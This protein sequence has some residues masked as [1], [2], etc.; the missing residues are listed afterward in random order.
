MSLRPLTM[1]LVRDLN[2]ARGR[3]LMMALALSLGVFSVGTVMSAYTI[4]TREISR[5]YLGTHPASAM[6]DIDHMEDSLLA[7]VRQ[8]PGIVDAEAGA[9]LLTRAQVKP[10]EWMPLLLFVVRDFNTSRI[11]TFLPESG[12][13]PP[14]DGTML[15]ERAALPL[16]KVPV[17]SALPVQAPDGVLRSVPVSGVVHDP[18]L[19]PA[20]QEQTAYGYIT[21]A[22]LAWL[23]G[24]AQL[25][26]L[27]IVVNDPNMDQSMVERTTTDL[28]A[29]LAGQGYS[30]REIRIPP[31]G[32]HPHQRQM[33]AILAMMFIFSLMTLVLSAILNASLIGALLAQQVRQIGIMKTLGARTRQISAAYLAMVALVGLVAVLVGVPAGKAAGIGLAGV[34]AGLLNFTLYSQEIPAWVFLLQAL[35][36]ILV[37]L[38]VALVPILNAARISVRA[39]INDYGINRSAFGT[40]RLDIWLGK[41]K[42]IDRTLLLSLRNTFR[43][44]SRLVLTLTLLAAAGGMFIASLN[45]RTAWEQNLADAANDRHYDLEVRL[46]Q[47]ASTA[48]LLPILVRLPGVQQA[49]TWNIAP[50]AASRPDGLDIVHTYPD[51]GHGSFT[52]RSVPRGSQLVSLTMLEGRWLQPGDSDALVLNHTAWAMFPAIKVGDPLTL[53]VSGQHHTFHVVGIVITPASAYV[54]QS[55]FDRAAGFSDQT[56]AFRLVM[57]RHDS[58]GRTATAA[59][60][61]NALQNQG[62]AIKMSI[63]ET[64][65]DAAV[66]GHVYILIFALI[67][68]AALMAAV[69]AIGLMSAIGSSI[70]ERTREFGIMRTIGSRSR[71]VLFNVISEGIFI[72]LMSWL[73]AVLVSLPLSALIG[74]LIG[75]MAFNL[76]LPLVLSPAAAAEWLLLIVVG[77][78]AASFYPAW[79][80]SRLTVRETLAYI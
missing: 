7:A 6:L 44:R 52:L 8:R 27:K 54:S 1:K 63:L 9:T 23:S 66:S 30:V 78:A 4:L 53:T 72:G 5:N 59:V 43:R 58:A 75:R 26:T 11:N 16:V 57:T 42:G 10:G 22:T 79:R 40:S 77:A 32:Q 60:V 29:W 69:G 62:I 51:G 31:D 38:L 34:V 39:A 19:A 74:D 3:F 37:P 45:V 46:N 48:N 56:N 12:A 61:E 41:L 55:A 28:A 18:G 13:W 50:A 64:R 17:G 47:P 80:A 49:E 68:M 33:T 67:V 20:W 15:L 71:T 21:P 25:N 76:P 14:P 2:Q 36:G 73:L 65:L 70:V 24:S 35:V